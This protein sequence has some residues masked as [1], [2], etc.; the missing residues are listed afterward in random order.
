MESQQNQ[1]KLEKG[2]KEYQELLE[3]L[4]LAKAN[5][6]VLYRTFLPKQDYLNA[7]YSVLEEEKVEGN[8]F[9]PIRKETLSAIRALNKMDKNQIY[10]LDDNVLH[11]QNVLEME[12]YLEEAFFFEIGEYLKNAKEEEKNT[13]IDFKY[14]LLTVFPELGEECLICP[15]TNFSM[16]TEEMQAAMIYLFPKVEE[17]QEKLFEMNDKDINMETLLCILYTKACIHLLPP[18]YEGIILEENRNAM[19]LGYYMGEK[20]EQMNRLLTLLTQYRKTK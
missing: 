4:S 14:A 13:L 10:T 15:K 12:I 5:E 7:N 1:K 19:N 3:I 11:N 8:Y 6:D 2:S 16:S 9:I 18:L 17:L 20:T